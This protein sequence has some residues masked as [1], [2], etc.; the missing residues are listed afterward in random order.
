MD[1]EFY[2]M[3]NDVWLERRSEEY[4]VIRQYELQVYVEQEW[5]M[6]LPELNKAVNRKERSGLATSITMKA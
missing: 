2:E 3:N 4:G 6:W 5:S 1:L